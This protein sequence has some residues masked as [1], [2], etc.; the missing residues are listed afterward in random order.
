M[1]ELWM[2][3]KGL[4]GVGVFPGDICPGTIRLAFWGW[5]RPASPMER[6]VVKLEKCLGPNAEDI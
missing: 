4:E 6:L 1:V 2:H 5:G 3:R